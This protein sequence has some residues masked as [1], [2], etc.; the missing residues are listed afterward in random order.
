[1]TSWEEEVFGPVASICK[2]T[3][4]DEAIALANAN[5]F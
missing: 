3:T 2:A 5:D 4:V 1:M